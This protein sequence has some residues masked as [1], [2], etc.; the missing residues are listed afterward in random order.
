MV[1]NG[2]NVVPSTIWGILT[3]KTDYLTLLAFL[4]LHPAS[5]GKSGRCVI[6]RQIKYAQMFL[7]HFVCSVHFPT[8]QKHSGIETIPHFYWKNDKGVKTANGIQPAFVETLLYVY[9]FLSCPTRIICG[10][11][12]LFRLCPLVFPL[13]NPFLA[14]MSSAGYFHARF[15]LSAFVLFV[16][17]F[18]FL[19]FRPCSFPICF[20]VI[21]SIL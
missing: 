8:V 7:R 4:I 20:G 1:S 19:F 21:S 9:G 6:L 10:C 17:F 11:P 5:H 14:M 2:R 15:L 12:G 3:T 16:L 13:L 18:I